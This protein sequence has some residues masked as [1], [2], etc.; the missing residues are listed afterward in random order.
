MEKFKVEHARKAQERQENEL[1]PVD[2][3]SKP[4]RGR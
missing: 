4:E 3:E 2:K 1:S